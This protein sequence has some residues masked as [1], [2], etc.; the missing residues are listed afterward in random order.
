MPEEISQQKPSLAKQYGL[1]F[2]VL[3]MFIIWMLPNPSDLPIS[4]QRMI[5]ILTFAIIV[6]I[7]ESMSY[8][9]SAFCIL[10]LIAF[11][12]GTAPSIDKPDTIIG[13]NAALKMAFS[14][15]SNSSWALVM[16]A[17]FL[18]AAMMITGLDK[19]IALFIM[20][21]I[22]TKAKHMVIGVILVGCILSFFVPST[23]AR[24]SC[25]VPIVIGI[26]RAFGV[27]TGSTFAAIMMIAVA[28]A[29][30]LWNVGV[31][32]AAAQNMVTIGFIKDIL[33]TD[34]SWIEWFIA[35]APFSAVMSV[36]LYFIMIKIL[37]PEI[38]EI[39]GGG[40]T[41]KKMQDEMGPVTLNE[42]KL[43]IISCILLFFWASE[44]SLHPF[45]TSSVTI[46]GIAIMFLQKIGIMDWKDA[47]SKINWGTIILFGVG[48]SLGSALLKTKAAI[49]LANNFVTIFDLSSMPILAIIAILGFFLI[50]I[51]LGFASATALAAAMIPIIISILQNVQTLGVNVLGVTMILQYVICF[52]FILPVNAPQNMIAY[53]TGYFSVKQFVITGIPLCIMA[54]LLILFFSATYWSWLGYV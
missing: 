42:K 13:T 10:A 11:G 29:D 7:N 6:W 44:K 4:G 45:D 5:G 38:D 52:G 15:F 23:T 41:I 20:S 27:K 53:S 35:A 16:A 40:A 17:L 19:R 32:T 30:S 33:K 48:I 47:V 34:I 2:A 25:V 28:Q 31:K 50:I 1:I 3:S 21:K 14:G 46:A 54:Y 8:P 51:H 37:P 22:G 39:P 18:A 24:V 26:I 49:W 43:M 12:V 9:A 36:V